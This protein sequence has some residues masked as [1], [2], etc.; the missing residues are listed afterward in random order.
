MAI[1]DPPI[2]KDI[3]AN[4]KVAL[5]VMRPRKEFVCIECERPILVAEPYYQVTHGGGG[6]RNI[7]YPDRVCVG[8]I[9]KHMG[10]PTT[11][12]ERHREWGALFDWLYLYSLDTNLTSR[13][14]GLTSCLQKIWQDAVKFK[15]VKVK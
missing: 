13:V 12:E 3:R 1:N 9:P 11:Y 6:L 14:K 7:K 5:L 2:K 15:E 4:H 8:C 10:I